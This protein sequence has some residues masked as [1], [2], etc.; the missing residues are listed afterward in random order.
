VRSEHASDARVCPR[1]DLLHLLERRRTERVERE[2]AVWAAHGR[3]ASLVPRP[4]NTT[5]NFGLLSA[6]AKNRGVIVP[7]PRAERPTR[8]DSSWA[9]LMRHAFGL[10]VR[11]SSI[12]SRMIPDRVRQKVLALSRGLC[13]LHRRTW[14][15]VGAG[16]PA[17]MKFEPLDLH[18]VRWRTFGGSDEE[19]NLVPI[20]PACH[21]HLHREETPFVTDAELLEEWARWKSFSLPPLISVG[22]GAVACQRRVALNLYGL[23]TIATVDASTSY[24]LF[25]RALIERVVMPTQAADPH[26]PLERTDLWDLST[27]PGSTWGGMSAFDVL[28]AGAEPIG[29]DVHVV[30]RLTAHDLFWIRSTRPHD[31]G[32]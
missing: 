4:T 30:F 32:L 27:D 18:H 14:V 5:V 24:G 13:C 16:N 7:K 23:E 26:F 1:G 8:P 15:R 20:C 29:F 28:K 31:R 17:G 22:D 10:D 25:R 19:E 9:V 11:M 2:R 6:H 3:L 21:A 12:L